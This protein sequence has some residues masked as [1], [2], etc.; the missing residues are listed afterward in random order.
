MAQV[1]F[2]DSGSRPALALA[3]L[4]VCVV[5]GGTNSTTKDVSSNSQAFQNQ[6]CEQKTMEQNGCLQGSLKDLMY[7]WR[8]PE[9]HEANC[10]VIEFVCVFLVFAK[11][12]TINTQ[13][14][15]DLGKAF[16]SFTNRENLKFHFRDRFVS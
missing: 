3:S 14:E 2:G 6:I 1:H 4:K 7:Q 8:V 10:F 5:V 9:I 12:L 16:L 11:K 15:L 13:M